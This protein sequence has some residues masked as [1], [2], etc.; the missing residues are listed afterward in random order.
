V[1]DAGA[2][3]MVSG[4]QL[5]RARS[6][7]NGTVRSGTVRSEMQMVLRSTVEELQRFGEHLRLAAAEMVHGSHVTLYDTI[8]LSA[9][10]RVNASRHIDLFWLIRQ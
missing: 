1:E 5:V 3:E 10:R 4:L 9:T 2:I 6:E 7:K 8:S